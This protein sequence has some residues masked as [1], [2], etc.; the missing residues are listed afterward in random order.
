MI[1]NGDHDF[2]LMTMTGDLDLKDISKLSKTMDIDG[3]EHLDKVDD[4]E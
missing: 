2:L 1:V 4:K 3:F